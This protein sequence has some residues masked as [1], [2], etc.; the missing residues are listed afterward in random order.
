MNWPND[1]AGSITSELTY[2]QSTPR[3]GGGNGQGVG[4]GSGGVVG[5]ENY[6]RIECGSSGDG[7]D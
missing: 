3:T 1:R 5:A 7:A 4:R 6:E 2:D